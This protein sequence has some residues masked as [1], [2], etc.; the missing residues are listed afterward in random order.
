MTC[1]LDEYLAS[2]AV[3]DATQ[4]YSPEWP[5]VTALMLRR[6]ENESSSDTLTGNRDPKGLPSLSHRMVSGGSPCATPQ[7]TR[8]R[9]P[10]GR[11]SNGKANDSILGGTVEREQ[12]ERIGGMMDQLAIGCVLISIKRWTRVL[13]HN[14][15]TFEFVQEM[16][17]DISALAHKKITT[18]KVK[19]NM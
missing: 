10:S 19:K 3:L 18:A 14:G 6:L 2:A 1:S 7:M 5:A 15:A 9:A 8:V 17:I 4:V 12:S 13:K 11:P 16:R